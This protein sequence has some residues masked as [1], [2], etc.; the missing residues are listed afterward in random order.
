MPVVRRDNYE[1]IVPAISLFNP[2]YD[3]IKSRIAAEYRTDR[4]VDI[5]VVIR[6]VHIARLDHQ[7]EPLMA[8]FRLAMSEH[9][10]GSPSHLGQRR[11]FCYVFRR[12]LIAVL[13]SASRIVQ[14]IGRAVRQ[15]P[16]AN[17]KESQ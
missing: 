16:A 2:L 5:V 13:F 1:R 4:I 12:V 10:Q 9:M 3:F 15:M 14:S 6:P 7:P 17:S 11:I 8:A